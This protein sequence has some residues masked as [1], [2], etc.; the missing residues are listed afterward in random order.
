MTSRRLD[1][2]TAA[3]AARRQ[4]GS[5]YT[6]DKPNTWTVCEDQPKAEKWDV[7]IRTFPTRAKAEA[8]IERQYDAE[9]RAG[10]SET[11]KPLL[12]CDYTGEYV[13]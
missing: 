7:E 3:I 4:T 9:E 6:S 1:D 11:C 5:I 12:R 13:G 10:E 8:F 2:I